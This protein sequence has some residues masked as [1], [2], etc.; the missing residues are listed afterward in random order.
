LKHF[1]LKSVWSYL[2]RVK[3]GLKACFDWSATNEYYGEKERIYRWL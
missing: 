2:N 1:S 3:K